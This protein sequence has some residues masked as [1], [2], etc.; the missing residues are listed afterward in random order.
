MQRIRSHIRCVKHLIILADSPLSPDLDLQGAIDFES[1]IQN[2]TPDF[3]WPSFPEDTP[4]SLCYT[5]GT[6]GRPKGVL[7]THRSNYLH[8]YACAG[9]HAIGVGR[10]DVVLINVPMY[11]ANSWGLAYA[12]PMAGA[13]IVFPGARFDGQSLFQLLDQQKVTLSAGVP[14]VWA[15]LLDYLQ[16][17]GKKLPHLKELHIGGSALPRNMLEAFQHEYDVNVAQGWGMTEMSPLGTVCR[18]K[19]FMSSYDRERQDDVRMKQGLPLF[20][21][22]LQIVDQDGVV[23]PHDGVTPGRLEVKGPWVTRRY[24][25]DDRDL[26]CD[27]VYRDT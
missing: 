9:K 23:L 21:V 3:D 18:L 26:G 19:P 27:D 20:G 16:Q 8:A 4:S 25:R 13:P 5:S 11:H 14:T 15:N 2:E 6:T 1:L 7:Y 24:Y 22:S 12:C 10:D 17:T